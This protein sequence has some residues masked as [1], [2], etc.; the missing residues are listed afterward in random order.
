M[1][2]GLADDIAPVDANRVLDRLSDLPISTWKFASD[3]AGALHIGP[4]AQDFFAA[5]GL[6]Q[7]DRHIG[8]IDAD[9]V[10]LAAIQGL[11]AET[12]DELERL[13]AENAELRARL[14]RLERLLTE[15]EPASSGE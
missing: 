13:R 11:H 7:S 9:G 6:G 4:T 3:A 12:Q 10:A 14:E 8:M 15:G 2:V 1:A 5:F